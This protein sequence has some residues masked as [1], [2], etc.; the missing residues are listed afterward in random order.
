MIETTHSSPRCPACPLAFAAIIFSTL[1]LCYVAAAIPIL[2]FVPVPAPLRCSARQA[3]PSW[4]PL[5][6]HAEPI[7]KKR[8]GVVLSKGK[9][10]TMAAETF[11]VVESSMLTCTL[12]DAAH[13][14]FGGDFFFHPPLR[15]HVAMIRMFFPPFGAICIYICL[16]LLL[17]GKKV[18]T[19]FSG[20]TG[21]SWAG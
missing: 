20:A 21:T 11:S 10:V 19:C 13:S 2:A 1:L 14:N 5:L 18:W 15:G 4:R 8:G 7:G 12:H 6:E 16:L 9:P 17:D 3:A